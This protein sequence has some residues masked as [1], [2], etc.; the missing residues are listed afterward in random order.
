MIR[1]LLTLLAALWPTLLL[2]QS[3]WEGSPVFLKPGAKVMQGKTELDRGS[4]AWPATVAK[5]N[6]TWLKVGDGWIRQSDAL[7][8][9]AA[10][11]FYT[12]QIRKNPKSPEGWLRRGEAR[13]AMY[14]SEAAL[15]DLN[16][17]IKLNPKD[18]QAYVVRSGAQMGSAAQLK[19]LDTAIEIDPRCAEAYL[20]RAMTH[21]LGNLFEDDNAPPKQEATEEENYEKAL[22]D[23]TAYI[24]LK[25]N[26]KDGYFVRIMAYSE[27][28]RFDD[29]LKDCTELIRQRPNDRDLYILRAEFLVEQGRLDDALKDLDRYL[30]LN[31]KDDEN[32]LIGDLDAVM[33]GEG[34]SLRGMVH[35]LQ[36][37]C[38]AALAD[39][40]AAVKAAPEDA[41][42]YSLRAEVRQ[43]VGDYPRAAAD[44]KKSLELNPQDTASHADLARL[45]AACPDDKIR[46]GQQALALG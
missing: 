3:E 12:A 17:A 2:A 25:P 19:D 24:K 6:G 30:A 7:T 13:A 18:A 41:T 44:W 16:Y 1:F 40:D 42:N 28:D 8:P 37:D 21:L 31:P 45:Y 15:K 38:A 43:D 9:E 26:D 32:V 36:G 29:V 46:D 22:S 4:I 27:L 5:V 11:E 39:L 33:P 10:V 35:Q 14:D 20:A 34:Y 23:C